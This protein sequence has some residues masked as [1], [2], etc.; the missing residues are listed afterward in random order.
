[1]GIMALFAL[2]NLIKN[3]YRNTIID[4][5]IIQSISSTLPQ[6]VNELKCYGSKRRAEQR[7][8]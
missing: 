3:C 2:G 8:S 7:S 6:V 1:M 4:F 5:E